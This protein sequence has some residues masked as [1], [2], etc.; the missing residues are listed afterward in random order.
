[1]QGKIIG[2]ALLGQP[3]VAPEESIATFPKRFTSIGRSLEQIGVSAATAQ[4]PFHPR[5]ESLVLS[6]R[7]PRLDISGLYV[8]G[9][10]LQPSEAKTRNSS[11]S[12]IHIES[13]RSDRRTE[14]E[15][16]RKPGHIS[17][18]E[19]GHGKKLFTAEAAEVRRGKAEDAHGEE[20][21]E[22]DSSRKK[23]VARR[24]SVGC[25]G[26][27]IVREEGRKYSER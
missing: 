10:L 3:A 5:L 2:R 6:E 12:G 21:K 20:L 11:P 26:A 23:R 19:T 13:H 8:A 17:S 9:S 15:S 1:V 25:V 16:A 14:I 22:H 7:R 27:R 24:R 4:L 18:A